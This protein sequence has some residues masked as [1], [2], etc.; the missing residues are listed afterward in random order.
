MLLPFCEA[1]QARLVLLQDREKG[2]VS[3][4]LVFKQ[5]PLMRKGTACLA[6]ERAE[7]A[8]V[9]AQGTVVCGHGVSCGR[10]AVRNANVCGQQRQNKEWILPLSSD[11]GIVCAFL[12]PCSIRTCSPA[13]AVRQHCLLGTNIM[14]TLKMD[15]V[16]EAAVETENLLAC[17]P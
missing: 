3:A 17:Q 4:E 9:L 1:K 12:C 2:M 10:K 5:P 16:Q 8:V 7:C 6:K 11:L 15:K 13:Y 14:E